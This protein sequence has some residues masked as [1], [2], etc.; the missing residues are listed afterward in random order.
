MSEGE[1]IN[2]RTAI[3]NRNIFK[4]GVGG[5]SSKSINELFD[6]DNDGI[7]SGVEKDLMSSAS[8]L[9]ALNSISPIVAHAFSQ[10][11]FR[12][13]TGSYLTNSQK[14]MREKLVLAVNKALMVEKL[15]EMP[16][17]KDEQLN[18]DNGELDTKDLL[19][20][21]ERRQ[22]LSGAEINNGV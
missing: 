18:V 13:A 12:I 17:R 2:S 19:Q 11:N 8:A 7:V 3:D 16:E 9:N 22:F 20:D 1:L 6:V 4:Q 21:I 15:N 14:I 10:E 5:F